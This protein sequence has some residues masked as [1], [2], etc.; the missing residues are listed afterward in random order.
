MIRSPLRQ[1]DQP[2]T[3]YRIPRGITKRATLATQQ[4]LHTIVG[5]GKTVYIEIKSW[6]VTLNSTNLPR[7]EDMMPVTPVQFHLDHDLL[8]ATELLKADCL[9]ILLEACSVCEFTQH[10][11]THIYICIQYVCF[12]LFMM[13]NLNDSQR[14]LGSNTSV[15]RTNR[16]VRLDI[17]EG[18]CE[19]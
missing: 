14:T 12:I 15:L 13:I 11:H 17:G 7:H 6:R 1:R 4:N 18:R 3:R 8:K 10:A 5:Y 9:S 2:V 19:T 16:I